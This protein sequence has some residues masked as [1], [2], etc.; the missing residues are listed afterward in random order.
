MPYP[1]LSVRGLSHC[2]KV[3]GRWN[4][5]WQRHVVQALAHID[6]DLEEGECLAL[7]GESGSGKTTLGKCLVRLLEPDAGEILFAG[8][9]LRALRGKELRVRRKAFQ[10][11]LQD[12]AGAFDP[13]L[14]IGR[15]VAEPL[16]VHQLCS[17]REI[18]ARVAELL[19]RVGLDAALAQRFP[20]QLSGGQRQ[21]AGI[22]RALATDPH[23]LVLDEP[24]SALDVSV[25][26]QILGLLK[27]LREH[28]GLT[29]LV[30]THDLAVAAQLADRVAVLHCGRLVEIG[31]SREILNHPD[32]PYTQQLL[33]AIPKPPATEQST[34]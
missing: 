18:G 17:D 24:V 33:A 6:L 27:D 10:M 21:R 32:H 34:R 30:I 3:A 16:I 28:R 14:R 8:E 7:V 1:Y 15:A 9:N 13:R 26:A 31:P 19:D 22:A 23:F 4:F 29:L 12:P 11:V 20:H 2:Y 5:P 25:Q